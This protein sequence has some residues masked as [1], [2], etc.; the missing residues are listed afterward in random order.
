MKE[1]IFEGMKICSTCRK[2]KLFCEFYK[3]GGSRIG[4]NSR[5]IECCKIKDRERYR[6]NR[7]EIIRKKVILNNKRRKIRKLEDPIYKLGC[8]LRRRTLLALQGRRKHNK[9]IELLGCTPEFLRKYLESKFAEGMS[10]DNYGYKGW[11]VDH[12]IPCSSFDL[13]KEEEQRKCFHYTN[14][15]PLWAE[16][17]MKKADKI[18]QHIP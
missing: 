1:I 3:L 6:T 16:D 2:T 18:I 12:I 14:L 5:C 7:E 13:S 4:I 8:N 10:W 11:H 17:N 9:T 15:Q